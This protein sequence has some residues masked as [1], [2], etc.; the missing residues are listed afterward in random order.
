MSFPVANVFQKTQSNPFYLASSIMQNVEI[1]GKERFFIRHILSLAS[2][3][4]LNAE[5]DAE[6]NVGWTLVPL[7]FFVSAVGL[8]GHTKT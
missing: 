2:G 5:L 3:W 1:S 7:R 8:V 4:S 6:Q